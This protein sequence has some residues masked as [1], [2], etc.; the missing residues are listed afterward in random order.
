MHTMKKKITP[1]IRR[2]RFTRDENQLYRGTKPMRVRAWA[3][4]A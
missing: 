2:I 1:M 4:A 3:A